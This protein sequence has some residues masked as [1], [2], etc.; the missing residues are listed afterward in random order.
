MTSGTKPRLFWKLRARSFEFVT[1]GTILLPLP[2]YFSP[3]GAKGLAFLFFCVA[4]WAVVTAWLKL[5]IV[6]AAVKD[7]I[8]VGATVL[9]TEIKHKGDDSP[10]LY[11]L[12]WN[13]DDG[14]LGESLPAPLKA[15]S[16][17][18]EGERIIVYRNELSESWWERDIF[19]TVIR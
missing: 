15:F 11:V 13:D 2:W 19:G 4:L 17:V 7:G 5:Q 10:D 3:D 18:T 9:G 12:N 8:R 1:I 6:L 16:D 14:H